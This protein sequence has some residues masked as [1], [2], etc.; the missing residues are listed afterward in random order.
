MGIFTITVADDLTQCWYHDLH[1]H[2]ANDLKS[3]TINDVENYR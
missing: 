3:V 1:H 2:E